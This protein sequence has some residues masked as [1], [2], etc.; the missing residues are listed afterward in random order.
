MKRILGRLI[1][2][3][4]LIFVVY[5]SYIKIRSLKVDDGGYPLAIRW[6]GFFHDQNYRDLGESLNA[7][8]GRSVFQ[9]GV[10]TRSAGWF[11][12]WSCDKV[13]NPDIIYSLNFDPSKNERYFC[14]SKDEKMIGKVLNDQFLLSDIEFVDRWSDPNTR[15][16]VCAYLKGV[17]GSISDGKTVL[18]HC[19]AGRDRTGAF[20]AIVAAL[21]SETAGILDQTMID[22]I[23]CDYQKTESLAESNYGRM[24]NFINQMLDQGG[25]SSFIQ[26]QCGIS[27]TEVRQLTHDFLH[28]SM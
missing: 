24:A 6:E 9:E 27:Q 4:I 3:I 17:T 19:N 13:G 14:Q 5:F 28:P 12:G 26:Q 20:S 21:V 22:A 16:T 11:S 7:C 18:V 25:V 2:L 1:L 8:L 15:D 10:I 23:E